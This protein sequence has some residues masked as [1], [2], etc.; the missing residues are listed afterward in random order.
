MENI[1]LMIVDDHSIVREGLKYLC[2]SFAAQISRFIFSI[3]FSYS[4]CFSSRA[5]ISFCSFPT[6]FLGLNKSKFCSQQKEMLDIFLHRNPPL[7]NCRYLYYI[8][9]NMEHTV[10]GKL[11]FISPPS[12]DS[13]QKNP[14]KKNSIN[15]IHSKEDDAGCRSW[16][17]RMGE[18]FPCF[19]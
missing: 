2:F 16:I 5:W 17:N 14:S 10:F 19:V 6:F 12:L 9:N 4:S 11:F 1:K 15:L 8:R 3:F 18:P 7:I 13:L